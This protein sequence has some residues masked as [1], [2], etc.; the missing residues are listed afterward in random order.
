MNEEKVDILEKMRSMCLT[1]LVIVSTCN[2]TVQQPTF[3]RNTFKGL[4][5]FTP[6][7]HA[8]DEIKAVYYYEQTVAVV[9]LGPRN[10]LHDCNII[11]V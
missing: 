6:K 11:E 10:E 7:T 2:L 5:G 8:K 4:T 9:D 1:F 3:F